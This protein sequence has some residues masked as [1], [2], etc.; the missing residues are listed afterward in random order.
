[1]VAL[2]SFFAREVGDGARRSG[3]TTRASGKAAGSPLDPS[4]HRSHETAPEG[5]SLRGQRDRSLV[6]GLRGSDLHAMIRLKAP[7][8]ELNS[9]PETFGHDLETKVSSATDRPKKSSAL[10]FTNLRTCARSSEKVA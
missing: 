8:S 6:L 4:S 2:L 1:M 10:G 3:E 9:A 5:A 7:V